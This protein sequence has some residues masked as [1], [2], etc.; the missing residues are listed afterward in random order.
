MNIWS[1]S[2]IFCVANTIWNIRL[3]KETIAADSGR[4][5]KWTRLCAWSLNKYALKIRSIADVWLL[6]CDW[7]YFFGLRR[8]PGHRFRPIGGSSTPAIGTDRGWLCYPKNG[9]FGP[10]SPSSHALFAC[11]HFDRQSESAAIVPF[12]MREFQ[13]G[14]AGAGV[15]QDQRKL[16]H[17]WRCSQSVKLCSKLH[18]STC[19]YGLMYEVS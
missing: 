3:A 11:V 7:A 1:D 16:L 9:H 13:L 2:S 12:A 8:S 5:L 4:R 17:I 10:F 19:M 15:D 18:T 14:G 6:N